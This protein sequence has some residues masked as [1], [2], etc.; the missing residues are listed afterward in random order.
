MAFA[1]RIGDEP[2]PGYRLLRFLGR[3]EFGVVW[4]ASA[5]GGTEVALKIIE[6]GGRRGRKELRALQ[7][8]KRIRHPHLVP[9]L[10]YWLK[11]A[12]GSILDP[13]VATASVCEPSG[14]AVRGSLAPPPDEQARPVELIIAMGLADKTLFDRLEECRQQGLEGI[15][16]EELLAH[17]DDAAKAIDFLNEPVHDLGAGPVAIQ[18]CDIKPHNLVLVGGATQVCDFGLARVVDGIQSATSTVGSIAYM[19]PEC[20]RDGLPSASSDQYSLAVS[21]V[22]LRTGV[23]PYPSE[24][25]AAV[26]EAILSGSLD[27]SLLPPAERAVIARATALDPAER[28]PTASALVAALREAVRVRQPRRS[29]VATLVGVGVLAGAFAAGAWGTWFLLSAR[30]QTPHEMSEPAAGPQAAAR[31]PAAPTETAEAFV[32][33]AQAELAKP[34]PDYDAVLRDLAKATE[35]D[36]SASPGRSEYA[37]AYLGRGTARLRD[38]QLDRA[39]ADFTQ[40]IHHHPRDYRLFSRRGTAWFLLQKWQ[41]AA[42][43]FA[44][45]VALEPSDVDFVN[46]GRALDNLG[47]HEQAG[48][49]FASALQ[50][51]PQNAEAYYFL[52]HSYRRQAEHLKAIEAYSRAIENHPHVADPIFS[53]ASAYADRGACYLALEGSYLDAAA[54]DFGR[55]MEGDDKM[56]DLAAWLDALAASLAEAGR[57]AEAVQWAQTAIRLAPD[58]PTRDKYRARLKRYQR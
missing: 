1:Y 10:A 41:E 43:D 58:E 23:L 2:I 25:F 36:P 52:G 16:V 21:Y 27:L 32:R 51:N 29:F 18:H 31:S 7:A 24:Q 9:L 46:L 8:V 55:A 44:Q 5:P 54:S 45:A 15:P 50:K 20:L 28:Y 6:M 56:A 14:S 42:D 13:A 12:D 39:I 34:S 53:L 3:G 37:E 22:E 17:M 48:A 40:G 57:F 4:H 11:A 35:L 26:T 33:R 47:R 30:D 49:S 19:S 38:D